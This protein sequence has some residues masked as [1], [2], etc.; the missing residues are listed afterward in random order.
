[1][2]IRDITPLTVT[3]AVGD[4]HTPAPGVILSTAPWVHAGRNRP[5]SSSPEPTLRPSLDGEAAWGAIRDVHSTPTGRER[6]LLVV[7][8]YA[9]YPNPDDT[10]EQTAAALAEVEARCAQ[11]PDLAA[12]VLSVLHAGVAT[13]SVDPFR[14]AGAV[15]PEPPLPPMFQLST[16]R[17]HDVHRP[18]AEHTARETAR[19]ERDA[20]LASVKARRREADRTARER[21]ALILDGERD[22]PP[23]DYD[24]K[25]KL[26]WA[27]LET[28][29]NTYA[30][31]TMLGKG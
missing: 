26:C 30:N 1:M 6:G 18:W 11:L 20:Q 4:E 22:M 7:T 21:I 16:V 31:A 8:T 27:D 25:V 28:L 17:P 10:P 9:H 12:R 3:Y 13:L 2:K 23:A 15:L 29:L 5:F 24:G 14:R 19:A